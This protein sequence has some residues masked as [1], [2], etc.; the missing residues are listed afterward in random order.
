MMPTFQTV[1]FTVADDHVAT[2]TLNRPEVLNAFNQQMC[3]EF[4]ALWSIIREDDAIHAVVLRAAGDRAFS[5]GVDVKAPLQYSTNVWSQADPGDWLSPKGNQVWKPVVCAVNGMA[6]GGAF[7]WIN[8]SDIVICSPDATFFDP[9]VTYGLTAVLE[10]IGLA[11]RVP[12]GEALR[13]AL[14]GLDE[15]ISAGRALAIGLVTEIVDRAELWERAHQI[16][17]GIAAKPPAAVQGTV[18]AIW[19]SLDVGRSVALARGRAYTQI[20]NPLS[21][22]SVDRATVARQ[23]FRIR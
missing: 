18:R 21:E 9:H 16:A 8:E 13:M 6:A 7:Y 14:M 4:A 2:V 19:E 23:Q 17:A 3:E 12:L 22:G 20:G 1:L 11:Y 15:R 5:T 10:P